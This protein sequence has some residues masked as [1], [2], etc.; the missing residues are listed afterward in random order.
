MTLESKTLISPT[1]IT[2]I[3]YGCGK[4]GSVLAV[5]VAK[6]HSVP[7]RCPTCKSEWFGGAADSRQNKLYEMIK[8]IR[9][10][11]GTIAIEGSAAL[12]RVS[13]EIKT[14]APMPR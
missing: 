9:A 14:S 13:L 8:Q 7:D 11:Q 6:E 4:C 3:H 12:L 10:V 1:D 2:S 5:Q